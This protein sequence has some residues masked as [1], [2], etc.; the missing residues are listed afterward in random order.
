MLCGRVP[1][2]SA[3]RSHARPKKAP[4][5]PAAGRADDPLSP[6]LFQAK[7][8][9]PGVRDDVLA[10]AALQPLD[11]LRGA[12]LVLVSAPAGFGKTTVLCQYE[13]ALRAA[14]TATAWLTLD[15]EDNDPARFS[16]YLR[17]ALAPVVHSAGT[18]GGLE[19]PGDRGAV[20][21]GAFELIDSLAA[22]DGPLAIFFDDFE[23]VAANAEVR[24]VVVRLLHTLGPKQQLVLGTRT[25]PDLGLARLRAGGQVVDIGLDRLR[26]SLEESRR[27]LRDASVRGLSEADVSFLHER[28]EGWPAALQLAVIALRDSPQAA[29]RLREFGG[30]RA[31]V[32]EYLAAEV[33]AGLAPDLREFAIRTSVL[34]SFC[35][36]LCEEV[37]GLAGA[38]AFIDRVG[39]ANLFLVSL[40]AERRWFRYHALCREFLRAELARTEGGLVP[41][42]CRRAAHWLAAHGRAADGVEQALRA[43]DAALATQLMEQS[44]TGLMHQG[45]IATLLRWTDAL[46]LERLVASPTLH[47]I[48][49]IVNVVSHRYERAGRLIEG[50]GGGGEAPPDA[51]GRDLLMLR[52]NLAIWGDRL[53]GLRDIL[54]QAVAVFSPADGWIYPS[55]MNCVGYLGFLEGSAEMARS[56]LA[57]S[58]SAPH[59]RDNAVVRTYTEGLA[60]MVHLARGELRDALQVAGDELDRLASTGSL[61]GTPGGIAAVVLADAL[62]ER[63][64]L[65]AARVLLDEH[66]DVAA[67]SCIPDLIIVGFIERSRIA[68]LE[69]DAAAAD[70]FVARLQRL[71]EERGL[72][73]VVAAALLEKSR[74]AL[75][76][77]RVDTASGHV[78]DATAY[79]LWEHAVFRGAFASDL[80]SPETG[81]ARLDLFRG[82]TA[83]VAPL[84]A[85]I[86]QAAHAGRRRRG[87]RLRGLHAQALW[88]SGQRKPALR[89]LRAALLDAAPEGLVRVLADEPWVLRDMLEHLAGDTAVNAFARRVADACGTRRPAAGGEPSS[90]VAQVLSEREVEVLT[91][92]AR[93]LSN[94]QIAAELSRSEATVATHLRR[95]YGK[96]GARTRTQAIAIARRGGLIS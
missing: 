43:G 95:I 53:D 44:A 90:G 76:E 12:R 58:K 32:A 66:L 69:G 2:M 94:K 89:E 35:A 64:E 28:S 91:R 71:G 11:R 40:D 5:S 23:H 82:A 21:G 15:V 73:R 13:K 39:R 36:E 37:T 80:E 51:R 48:S 4:A 88:L 30:S 86:A 63:N 33:L 38:A 62:F 27:F 24:G 45:Q 81:A 26:F 67:D 25:V 54:Q 6:R 3:S 96:L 84:E 22:Y 17:G 34:D 9:P 74:V 8:R 1:P 50:F 41:D 61:Y 72:A 78:R 70:E 60:A 85:Q 18:G 10:R 55:M 87:L 59:H 56:A 77:G 92:L 46:A 14:G 52:F 49:A 29:A 75:A 65:A 68:R 93:G 19:T 31:E 79:P 20:M 57:A 47:F 42:L 16:A 7:L 83:A